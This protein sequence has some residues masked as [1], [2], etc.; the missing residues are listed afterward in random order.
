MK[1]SGFWGHF[2][3]PTAEANSHSR[4]ICGTQTRQREEPDQRNT[5][6]IADTKTVTNTRE[7]ADQD[8][9][10]GH[11]CAIPIRVAS[12]ETFTKQ[13]EEPDQDESN[14]IHVAVPRQSLCRTQTMTEGR[15]E[16]DQDQ[17]SYGYSPI[18]VNTKT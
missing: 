3:E 10:N 13:R 11:H 2:E 6:V 15:E 12:G 18:P 17:S 9:H 14:Q 8:I 5:F 7:E 16:P 4:A 1:T